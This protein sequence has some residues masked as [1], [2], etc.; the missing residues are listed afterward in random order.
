MLVK[1]LLM[2]LI[3][4]CLVLAVA[5]GVNH[6]FGIGMKETA[7]GFKGAVYTGIFL[8]GVLAYHKLNECPDK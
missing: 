2:S 1:K 5:I 3:F 4:G 8:F 6:L 7:L